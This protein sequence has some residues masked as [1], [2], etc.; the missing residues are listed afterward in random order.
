MLDSAGIALRGGGALVL[1]V[2]VTT[3][4][5]QYPEGLVCSWACG[6]WR[7]WPAEAAEVA[8][9]EIF[10]NESGGEFIVTNGR[11]GARPEYMDMR[12]KLG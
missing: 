7:G 9:Q 1:A 4:F 6:L 2:T 5:G 8:G 3:G 10:E 11:R 12:P